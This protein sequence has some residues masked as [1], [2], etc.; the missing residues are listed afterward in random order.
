MLKVNMIRIV[1]WS[2]IAL[3]G[4]AFLG[5]RLK[6]AGLNGA[7]LSACILLMVAALQPILVSLQFGFF[8]SNTEIAFSAIRK[9][10]LV[11]LALLVET[12]CIISAAVLLFWGVSGGKCAT[13]LAGTL[14]AALIS[15]ISWLVNGMLYDRSRVDFGIR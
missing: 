3:A 1:L 6:G 4:G 7:M 12:A 5:W 9:T 10:F 2:P 11:S 8:N 13:A 15:S 14:I